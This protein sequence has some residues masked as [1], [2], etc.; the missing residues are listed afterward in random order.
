[1]EYLIIAMIVSFVGGIWLFF[2]AFDRFGWFAALL[3][4][5]AHL[6]VFLKT[7]FPLVLVL[8]G[9][10]WL[11]GFWL[12]GRKL[13]EDEAPGFGRH[14]TTTDPKAAAE[15]LGLPSVVGGIK[16]DSETESGETV[17]ELNAEMEVDVE[18]ERMLRLGE[19]RE[20]LELA[21]KRLEDAKASGD[22]RATELLRKYILRIE[23]GEY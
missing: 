23:R 15:K 22:I 7:T 13:P 14:V 3:L 21:E 5:G 10:F 19:V 8:Y 6:F 4:V 17:G 16:A 1:M 2:D 20:A 11:V 9:I 18:L 12:T